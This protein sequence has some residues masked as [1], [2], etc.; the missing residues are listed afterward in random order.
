[1]PKLFVNISPGSPPCTPIPG[2]GTHS[3]APG[4]AEAGQHASPEMT[5]L[6]FFAQD[7]KADRWG[8][9]KIPCTGV[10]LPLLSKKKTAFIKTSLA[11]VIGN[12]APHF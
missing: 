10:R 11:F 3:P 1:M 7:P 5:E 8:D 4:W 9:P 2:L 12:N 6:A